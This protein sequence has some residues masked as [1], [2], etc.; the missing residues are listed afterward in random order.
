VD[1]IERGKLPHET[2]PELWWIGRELKCKVCNTRFR[3]EFGDRERAQV[4][5]L[6][7]GHKGEIACK[8]PLPKCGATV[9]AVFDLDKPADPPV[10]A[11]PV[12]G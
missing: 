11:E 12:T 4:N 1:I 8:C 9:H 3:P 5:F 7:M 10:V 6:Q 2:D